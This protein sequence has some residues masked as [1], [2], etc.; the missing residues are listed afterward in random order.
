MS[1]PKHTREARALR[2]TPPKK[3]LHRLEALRV[4]PIDQ[5]L[6]LTVP[7]TL[8]QMGFSPRSR[9]T[10]YQ[11][12]REDPTFPRLRTI[13]PRRVGILHDELRQWLHDRPVLEIDGV[14][15]AE[16]AQNRAAARRAAG[17]A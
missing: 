9:K 4:V 13:G 3:R 8:A 2:S 12:V 5:R 17:G 11:I 15:A 16:R 10:L 14:G 1:A 7:E 6:V